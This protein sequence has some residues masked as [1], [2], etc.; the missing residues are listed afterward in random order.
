MYFCHFEYACLHLL[1]IFGILYRLYIN[2][3]QIINMRFGP[4]INIA[5]SDMAVHWETTLRR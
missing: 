5:V 3:I 2:N 4:S 1:Y